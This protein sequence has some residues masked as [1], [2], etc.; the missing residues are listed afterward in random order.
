MAS[1]GV[2]S[3]GGTSTPGQAQP[4]MYNSDWV[5]KEPDAVDKLGGAAGNQHL[6]VDV[7]ER[8]LGVRYMDEKSEIGDTGKRGY[9]IR[10]A[11]RREARQKAWGQRMG[12]KNIKDEQ[13]EREG[14]AEGK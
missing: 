6:S 4:T 1:P 12:L 7:S 9:E 13:A 3:L 5:R 10:Q 8:E 14:K 2:A 11:E